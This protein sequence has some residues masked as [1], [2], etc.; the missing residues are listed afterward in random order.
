[1]KSKR[2]MIATWNPVPKRVATGSNSVPVG[3]ATHE[4]SY[5]SFQRRGQLELPYTKDKNPNADFPSGFGLGASSKTPAV[6]PDQQPLRNELEQTE[7]R[8]EKLQTYWAAVADDLGPAEWQDPANEYRQIWKQEISSASERYRNLL[9]RL[10][11]GVPAGQK[12]GL[13]PMDCCKSEVGT[14]A[15]GKLNKKQ[16]K[17]AR[18]RKNVKA[19]QA[20]AEAWTECRLKEFGSC[21]VPR[22]SGESRLFPAAEVPLHSRRGRGHFKLGKWDSFCQDDGANIEGKRHLGPSPSV[23]YATTVDIGGDLVRVRRQNFK[24]ELSSDSGINEVFFPDEFT[25]N[26]RNPLSADSNATDCCVNF[27]REFKKSQVLRVISTDIDADGSSSSKTLDPASPLSS[28]IPVRNTT[29]EVSDWPTI[30]DLPKEK[31]FS[32]NLGREPERLK[33]NF[34]ENPILEPSD[35]HMKASASCRYISD[36]HIPSD[37]SQKRLADIE[38]FLNGMRPDLPDIFD[39]NDTSIPDSGQ[40]FQAMTESTSSW[41]SPARDTQSSRL[42]AACLSS[43]RRIETSPGPPDKT[44]RIENV[45]GIKA[46]DLQ[47]LFHE[48]DM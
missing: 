13:S 10:E 27:E 41:H 25:Q 16:M 9:N 7:R 19:R 40:N 47:A 3:P 23:D 42:D 34:M 35:T 45:S 36:V 11:G 1:M 4:M 2:K 6:I 37:F 17:R 18:R 29:L 31:M 46:S 44:L 21:S 24:K 28:S 12:L 26:A 48:Y 38:S 32:I 33:K 14:V 15:G 43:P 20:R 39:G 8:I 5:S 30:R 22:E